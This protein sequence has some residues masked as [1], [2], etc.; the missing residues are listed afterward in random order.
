[1]ITKTLNSKHI[2]AGPHQ[3]GQRT[4]S[5]WGRLFLLV[6]FCY[7]TGMAQDTNE[8]ATPVP[9]TSST[10]TEKD[11]QPTIAEMKKAIVQKNIFRPGRIL[12]FSTREV[13][14]E[15]L[16]SKKGPVKLDR[17]FKVIASESIKDVP[18][19]Y[20]QF[21]NPLEVRPVTVGEVIQFTVKILEIHPTYI[22]VT[23]D[24]KKVRI[25][26][27]ETSDDAL[28]RLNGYSEAAYTFKGITVTDEGAFALFQIKGRPR[29]VRVEVGDWLGND[30]IIDIKSEVVTVRLAGGE[31]IL[32]P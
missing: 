32:L 19:V 4:V 14:P 11:K 31:E 21:P 25:D 10:T 30:Q 28:D 3:A 27:G 24:G 16:P 17:P 18:H 29:P 23:Y 7:V 20:L 8:K 13:K 9:A 12:P 6:L 22:R 1:M 2:S 15:I 26:V 5:L